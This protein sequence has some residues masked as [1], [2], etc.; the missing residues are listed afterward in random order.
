MS[1]LVGGVEGTIGV[2]RPDREVTGF[3]GI[4]EGTRLGHTIPS[5]ASLLNVKEAFTS[6]DST[7]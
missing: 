5:F 7:N 3:M 2:D 1:E 6:L 4:D